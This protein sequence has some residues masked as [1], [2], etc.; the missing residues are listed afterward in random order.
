M[1]E[2]SESESSS[3]QPQRLGSLD[4]YRG[5]VMF[6]MLA[7]GLR[8]CTVAE[9]IP[10][11]GFW[12]L[13]CHH[14]S[15]VPWAGCSLHDLI[16]P[17]C[18]FLVGVSLP[19]SIASR[20]ARGSGFGGMFAHA[21]WRSVLL[22]FLGVFLRSLHRDQTYWTFEDTLTQIGLG[23]AFLFLLGWGSKRTQWTA[24]IVVVVGIWM[25]F[26]LYP[27]P[28][29]EFDY[30]AVGVSQE[31]LAQNG[32]SD[33]AAH[34][35]KNSNLAWAFDTWFMNLFPRESAFA[36]NGGGY[37][38]LS[39]IPTLGTMILGLIAGGWLKSESS[40]RARMLR[41]VIAGAVGLGLGWLLDYTGVCP[42]VKRIW[43][44]AWVLFS[45]GWCFLFLAV[46][47]LV[48]D[49][50]KLRAW[51]FVFMVF[52]MNSIV[53]YCMEWLCAGF[54]HD[55]LER[56]YGHAPFAVFGEP[57][58]RLVEGGIVLLILWAMLLWMHRKRVYVRI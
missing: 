47:Y 16:Q 14:Q 32:H 19:F 52:G 31:W 12:A 49:V 39:F 58:A 43:T 27:T 13:L 46:F 36:F 57:Y 45:G 35:N 33:F 50:W 42:N 29:V 20:K 10:E 5:L 15:H 11:S 4:A 24:F 17:S 23:Y 18:S 38:T 2:I 9:A 1:S 51:A 30:E 7:E 40:N 53:A 26:A 37:S 28:S 34:W 6:L 55:A 48:I 3:P 8:L 21:V 56:H 44:P 25:A 41:L 22:I 54:F